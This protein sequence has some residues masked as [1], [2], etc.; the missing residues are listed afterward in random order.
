MQDSN[1][2]NALPEHLQAALDAYRNDKTPE[3]W[4]T[5]SQ[6]W[7]RDDVE[8]FDALKLVNPGFPDP[9]PLPVEGLVEDNTGF[10]QWPVLP[11]PDEVRRAILFAL[12]Q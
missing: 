10:F 2:K 7:V 1:S 5:L 6:L 12:K 4:T 8:V 11:E 9:L 3:S